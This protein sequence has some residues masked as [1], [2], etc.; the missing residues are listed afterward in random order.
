LAEL[1]L[2]NNEFESAQRYLKSAIAE[3]RQVARAILLKGQLNY[4]QGAYERALRL[5]QGL[6]SSHPELLELVVVNMINCYKQLNDAKGLLGLIT[7]LPNIPKDAAAFEL[8]SNELT[9][10]LGQSDAIEHIYSKTLKVGLSAP[11]AAYLQTTLSQNSSIMAHQQ[12]L[13]GNL[14]DRA[15]ENVFEYSCVACGFNTKALHW[16]CVNCGEWDSFR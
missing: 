3:D 12:A 5:W 16:L 13:L 6:A 15:K 7:G 8:W 2:D 14:L 10:L 9:D 1:A 11:V 4:R